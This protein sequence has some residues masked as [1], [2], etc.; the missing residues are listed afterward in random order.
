M[1]KGLV[2]VP[3]ILVSESQ[4]KG[5]NTSSVRSLVVD[6]DRIGTSTRCTVS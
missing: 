3:G 6:E 4:C 2:Q 1:K 5:T